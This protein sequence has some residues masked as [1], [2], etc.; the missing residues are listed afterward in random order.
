MMNMTEVATVDALIA[1]KELFKTFK[2][3]RLLSFLLLPGI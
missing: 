3:L 1:K 2:I